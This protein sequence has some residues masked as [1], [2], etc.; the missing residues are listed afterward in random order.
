[1]PVNKKNEIR[2]YPTQAATDCMQH[3]EIII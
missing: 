3:P 2:T 1:M